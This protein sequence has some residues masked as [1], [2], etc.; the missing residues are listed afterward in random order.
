MQS[1][2]RSGFTRNDH[3]AA[4]KQGVICHG[5]R[6]NFSIVFIPESVA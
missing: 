1:I 2:H 3:S 5:F 6:L 4:G